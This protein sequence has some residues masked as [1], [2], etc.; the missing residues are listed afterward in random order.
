MGTFD[1]RLP[2]KSWDALE[3]L[4][5][6]VSWWPDLLKQWAPSGSGGG[7]RLA[8]RD[9]RLNFYLDGQS[10]AEIRFGLG[11]HKPTLRVHHKYVISHADGQKYWKC[12]G[13]SGLDISGHQ[14]RWGGP[15]M[16]QKWMSNSRCYGGEE[17]RCIEKVLATSPKVIDLEM[18][19]P[20]FKEPKTA[21]RMDI[22]ALEPTTHKIR[23]VFWEAKMIGDKRLRSKT[24]PEVLRQI[25]DYRSYLNNETRRQDIIRAYRESCS[26]MRKLHGMAS[27]VTEIGSL[28]PVILAATEPDVCMEIEDLPRLLV[29]DD[30]KNRRKD[31]WQGHLRALCEEVPVVVDAGTDALK[32]LELIPGACG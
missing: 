7:L 22:V 31:R 30:G 29:F 4:M 3:A 14:V 20:A 26:I 24:K 5:A 17:K 16:L 23:L 15:D 25:R 28:D 10:I 1:R 18:G 21:L 12:S 9:G 2:E 11:G 13:E 32:P 19:L 8:I 27:R 6:K